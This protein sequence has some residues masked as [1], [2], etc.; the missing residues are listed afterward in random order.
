MTAKEKVR[1]STAEKWLVAGFLFIVIGISVPIWL[2]WNAA[3]RESMAEQDLQRIVNAAERF[4]VEYGYWPSPH[5]GTPNDVR[6]GRE[7]GNELVFN[8]MRAIDGPG[9]EGHRLNPNRIQ[10]IDP[11]RKRR[12]RSGVDATG[13]YLDPWNTPYQVVLDTDMNDVAT[14]TQTIYPNQVGVGVVSWSFGPDRQSDTS[15]DILSW[16]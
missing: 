1:F 16:E 5:M 12:G 8:I 13:V 4:F 9:N 6:Y 7:I 2:A 10:Y 11:P 3:W 14:L 15:A